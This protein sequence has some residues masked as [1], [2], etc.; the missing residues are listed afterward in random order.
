MA[1]VGIGALVALLGNTVFASEPPGKVE[2]LTPP[3]KPAGKGGGANSPPNVGTI[4]LV[5]DSLAVGLAPRLEALADNRG[6]VLDSH[7]VGGS[8]VSQW[9]AWIGDDLHTWKPVA[10]LASI[11]GNDFGRTDPD[12]VAADVSRFVQAVRAADARLFWIEPPSFP[13]KDTAGVRDMWAAVPD[14]E[15]FRTL[16]LDIPRASD[17]IHPTPAGYTML[18]QMLWDWLAFMLAG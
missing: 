6:V 8:N 15:V 13:F 2:P 5:G 3:A 1:V 9:A 18:A 14:L 17:Q 10:V 11:G 16:G 7:V 12:K 4:L